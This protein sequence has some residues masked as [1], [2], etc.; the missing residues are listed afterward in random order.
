MKTNSCFFLNMILCFG[1]IVSVGAQN[2]L[3]KL[4]KEYP[5]TPQYESSAFKGT[6]ISIGQSVENRRAGVLQIM[7]M[8]RSWNLPNANAQRFVAD[9]WSSRI[10]VEYG[11]T[12]KL[13]TGAGW[14][15]LDDVYNGYIKYNL[16]RQYQKSIQQPISISFFQ[17]MSYKG[18]LRLP[19]TNTPFK[20]RTAFTSQLLIARK[21]TP[22]FSLQIAPTFIH[23]NASGLPEDAV[24]HFAL[25]FGARYKLGG[26]VSLVSEY[27]YV[28]NPL[29]S[30]PTYGAFALGVNWDVRF[31]LLQFQMTNTRG[32]VE[33]DFIL[34]TPN[35]FN[36]NDGNFVFGVNAIFALHLQKK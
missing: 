29:R 15:S 19:N 12:D 22:A 3:E 6:R 26:H 14:T 20:G 35:N 24:N 30:R 27:Y 4:D 9:K 5:N 25:G 36:T 31:L 2:L 18:D 23:R 1:C 34:Q 16:M 17:N 21:F 33:D 10:G 13:S 8:N 28:A 32:M 11:I 7:T